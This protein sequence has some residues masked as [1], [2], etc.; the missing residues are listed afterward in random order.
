MKRQILTT[1]AALMA[2]T[3][4]AQYIDT[5][6]RQ[7]AA[8]IP[9]S[10]LGPYQHELWN[11]GWKFQKG[12]QPGAEQPQYDDTGW[13]SLD[14]PHDFQFEMAW[15]E[16][17][18]GA[19]GFKPMGEG[20]YRKAFEAQ[21][22]W[23][24]RR[25]TLDFGGIMYRGDVY[26]NG[27]KVASTDYG[28]VGFEADLTKY[29]RYDTLNV[30]AVYASTGPSKGS[31]WYTG[32]GLFRDVY[33][34]VQNPTH[35]ARHG[36]YITTPEVSEVEA[37]IQVQVEVDGWQ[38]H[39]ASVR[40]VIRDP[41]GNIVAE[42]TGQ[43]PRYTHQRCSEVRLEP[44]TVLQPE[45][46]DL[47]NPNLYT[48][49][50]TVTA[51]GVTADSLVE[52]FG[53]RWLEFSSEFGFKLNGKKVFLQGM[54][55]HHDMG[56]L[57]VA[58]FDRGIERLMLQ[59]KAWGYNCIRCSHNPYSESFT[60]I[61]D[62]VGMLVVDELIDKWSDRDYWGG[63][64]PFT[65]LWH[66][67]IPEWVKRD[68]NC[69]SVILWSLGN[70]LQTRPDWSGFDTNDWG[71]T[72]YNIFKEYLH[73]W[74]D[75]RLTTVAMFP[76]RE[77]SL[78]KEPDGSDM[79]HCVAPELAQ[80]TEVSSFNY[81]SNCY[82]EYL[83]HNP[84]MILFQS[85][86]QT[87]QFLWGYYN[88]DRSRSVG[89][90][91]W[92]AVE[93]W[94]ESNKWPKKGW[95]YSFFDHCLNPQPTAW[96]V[97]SAFIADEPVVHLAINAG[98]GESVSWNDVQVGSLRLNENW[99]H[100]AGSRQTVYTFSNCQE[101]ELVQNGRSLG[102]QQNNLWVNN[103][104]LD[105]WDK[106]MPNSKRNIIQWPNVEFNAGRLTAIG[107]NEGRE[108]C[109]HQIETT[110]RAVALKVEVETPAP[111]KLAKG[112]QLAD[113]WRADGMDLEYLK[114][115]AVDAKGRRVY[116]A[117]GEVSVQVE[118][119]ATLHA[120]DNAD[121]YTDLLFT[122]DIDHKPLKTGFMQAILRSTREA[123]AVTVRVSCPGLKG[124]TLKLMT[125]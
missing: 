123:G 35:I 26:L 65:S 78:R 21:E 110:G 22:V 32:G 48:A 77:G 105:K 80:V 82:K 108:V 67:L 63:R 102:R 107:Y 46:W 125:R 81:Q 72:T 100:E 96:L 54:A 27:H 19:R 70:E 115:W 114:I 3:A 101:V 51:D 98:E 69:P 92:G 91:Y 9:V 99:N 1:M 23:R 55:N 53:V 111:V 11:F 76:A 6:D 28:Y 4:S 93:Y 20:W 88:M 34:Q 33:L 89:M 29:L 116:D 79:E 118:G 18:G 12:A 15:D 71:V 74:D 86:C 25:V 94:G 58:S 113:C 106:G 49:E 124:A 87:S 75:T 120:L 43:M 121:H 85:E 40:A 14:L 64:Q 68:R 2:L 37:T 60:R 122:P 36:I 112:E 13:R 83:E 50:V 44:V 97:R 42:T 66:Q 16:E 7:T 117:T 52:T 24:D 30:V 38:K 17:A 39:D 73:R 8:C 59:A 47:D 104:E 61:A 90:A 95:N 57:G 10:T 62:R 31:R 84:E 56:A 45:L 109:R 5:Q 119:A 103:D 41:E